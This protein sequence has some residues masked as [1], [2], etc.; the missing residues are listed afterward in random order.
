MAV[1]VTHLSRIGGLVD[2]WIVSNKATT[3]IAVE[4]LWPVRLIPDQVTIYWK[5]GRRSPTCV[6]I[7]FRRTEATNTGV[8]QAAVGE[9]AVAVNTHS[10]WTILAAIAI[11]AMVTAAACITDARLAVAGWASCIPVGWLIGANNRLPMFMGAVEVADLM[12]LPGS[13]TT[14]EQQGRR[15]Q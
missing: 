1:V 10:K 11:V 5:P 14:G 4:S 9:A 15:H 7:C 8:V 3:L 6:R 12:D 2:L 13:K